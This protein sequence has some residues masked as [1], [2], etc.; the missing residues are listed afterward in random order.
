MHALVVL[1]LDLYHGCIQTYFILYP[2]CLK[3]IRPRKR[4]FCFLSDKLM[5]LNV[6]GLFN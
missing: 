5:A 1:Y 3:K 6:F 4:K 2:I